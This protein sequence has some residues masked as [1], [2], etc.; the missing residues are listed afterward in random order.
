MRGNNSANKFHIL[1]DSK[2]DIICSLQ[3]M[4]KGSQTLDWAVLDKM[5][6]MRMEHISISESTSKKVVKV[7]GLPCR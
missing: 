4:K 5:R 2:I 6:V 3:N 7:R 1:Q